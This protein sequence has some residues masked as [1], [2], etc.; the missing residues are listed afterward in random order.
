M[1]HPIRSC[2]LITAL[3][4]TCA[5]AKDPEIR[6]ETREENGKPVE[7][8]FI[9]G[10]K[11]HETDPAKQPSRR[12]LNPSPTMPKQPR[13]RPMPSCSSTAARPR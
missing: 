11:V 9:D 5:F 6:K 7:Y 8:M 4:L 12:S 1:N 2:F 10:I 13:P 3:S